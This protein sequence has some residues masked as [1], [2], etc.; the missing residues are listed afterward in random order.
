D[1]ARLIV[2]QSSK[3]VEAAGASTAQRLEEGASAAR[4]TLAELGGMMAE[5][6]ARTVQMPLAAQQQ[7]EQVRETL[8]RGM[9]ELTAQARRM[10]SEAQEIDAA[11]QERVRRNFDMLS[12][13]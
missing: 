4:A 10:A 3:M 9:D 13:A 1:E 8:A 12:E 5:I 7:V 11:F 2:E 6:E